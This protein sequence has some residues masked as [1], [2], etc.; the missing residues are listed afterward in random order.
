MHYV[1][2]ILLTARFFY[3]SRG[4]L[5]RS[6]GE[7]SGGGLKK[8]TVSGRREKMVGKSAGRGGTL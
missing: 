3:S 1:T 7:I 4:L 6:Q 8:M 5:S 2:V